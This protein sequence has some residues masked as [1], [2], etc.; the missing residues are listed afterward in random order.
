[1]KDVKFIE[2]KNRIQ[3]K[4]LE[5]WGIED[6]NMADPL[7]MMLLDVFVHELYYL[8]QE[9]VESDN[10]IIERIAQEIV[11]SQ[12]NLP[13][14]A[15]TLAST[16]AIASAK[17]LANGIYYGAILDP[18]TGCESSVRLAV[19]ISINDP[20]TPTTADATQDFCLVNAPT[21][22]NIQV[23]ESNVVWY[24]SQA[25]TT[26]IAPATALANGIYYGAVLDP[27]T[28]CE[29][30]VRLQVTIT[31]TDPLTPTTADTTQD[32]CLVNAPTV[33]NIQVNEANVVWYNSLASTT[34]IASANAL[35]NGI[36]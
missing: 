32:F 30:A 24:N 2:I 15:H 21:V 29:S 12:W 20:G 1:M 3:K 7:V 23:N 35:A 16:T 22:A 11:P 6:I 13:M 27:V 33:A 5:I 4:C 10:K 8:H 17:A 14:P 18:V 31:V 25:S 9:G 34:A 36:Y 28:G 26:A 19:T